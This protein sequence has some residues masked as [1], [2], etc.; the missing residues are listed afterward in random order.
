MKRMKGFFVQ[1][2]SN[3]KLIFIFDGDIVEDR[4]EGKSAEVN[5]GMKFSII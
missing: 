1:S 2:C 4:T 5:V 3:N